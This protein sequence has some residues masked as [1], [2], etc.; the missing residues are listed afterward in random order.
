MRATRRTRTRCARWRT[1]TRTTS[2]CL[3]LSAESLV[4]FL[5]PWRLWSIDWKA[6]TR[7]DRDRDHAREGAQE[8]SQ[9]YR[10]NH[11]YIHAVEAT[12][13]PAR[14]EAAPT[15][16]ARYPAPA[17]VHMPSHIYIRS[18]VLPR[19]A[20]VN[21]HAA[22]VDRGLHRHK[23]GA[24]RLSAGVLRSQHP[25]PLLRADDRGATARR[26]GERPSA[27]NQGAAARSARDADG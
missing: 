14:A 5:H 4:D 9:Q 25:L 7:H 19:S 22:Q 18:W 13:T 24:G 10:S 3:R 2:T 8:R 21:A 15:G 11:Y 16:S 12:T 17:I 23:Q 6:R 1:S 20:E 26:A 27:G